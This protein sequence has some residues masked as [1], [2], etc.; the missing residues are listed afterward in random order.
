MAERP[1]GRKKSAHRYNDDFMTEVECNNKI[2]TL[3][4]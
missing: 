2:K 1:M 4:I 3:Q